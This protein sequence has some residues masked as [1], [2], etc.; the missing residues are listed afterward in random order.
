MLDCIVRLPVRIKLI[1]FVIS[2]PLRRYIC[3]W[4]MLPRY[5]TLYTNMQPTGVRYASFHARTYT[6]ASASFNAELSLTYTQTLNPA[7]PRTPHHHPL[8]PSPDAPTHLDPQY[9]THIDVHITIGN[10]FLQ[11]CFFFV[12]FLL[13]LLSSSSSA[14]AASEFR[15]REKSINTLTHTHR[16]TQARTRVHVHVRI[17]IPIHSFLPSPLSSFSSIFLSFSRFFPAYL[18]LKFLLKFNQLLFLLM[19]THRT[20]FHSHS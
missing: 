12:L 7:P 17:S 11:F 15:F 9:S 13:F 18:F 1:S 19:A 6:L 2:S 16:H 14:C 10:S 4:H 3:T 5:T 20:Y 8:L